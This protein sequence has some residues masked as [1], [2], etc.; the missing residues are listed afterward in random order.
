MCLTFLLWLEIMIACRT[1][2][3]IEAGRRC[4]G[5]RESCW[6]G[7]WR[8][9][10]TRS[11]QGLRAVWDLPSPGAAAF[12]AQRPD[13][14]SQQKSV[15]KNAYVVPVAHPTTPSFSNSQERIELEFGPFSTGFQICLLICFVNMTA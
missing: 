8:R 2:P 10:D 5:S 14:S 7:E 15:L 9:R 1:A 6:G 4:Q 3:E 13:P 12:R 11:S